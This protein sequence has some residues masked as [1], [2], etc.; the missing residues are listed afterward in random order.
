M[1]LGLWY[2]RLVVAPVSCV[3]A[4]AYGGCGRCGVRW[5]WAPSH[6]VEVTNEQYSGGMFVLCEACWDECI[7]E[8]R[9]FY[10]ARRFE[11]WQ[12]R[13]HCPY[14]RAELCKAVLG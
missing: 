5:N 14:S 10:H 12:A 2:R 4:P 9:W 13:G 7:P 11:E 8:E 3:V 1:S 6:Q